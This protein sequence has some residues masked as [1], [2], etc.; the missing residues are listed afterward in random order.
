MDIC[1]NIS[2][3]YRDIPCK[4]KVTQN[5]EHYIVQGYVSNMRECTYYIN[6]IFL[7][8]QIEHTKKLII[9]K[10]KIYSDMPF[11]NIISKKSHSSLAWM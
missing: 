3:K 6:K 8:S 1:L 2:G 11:L 7:E 5:G 10:A 9:D 4:I